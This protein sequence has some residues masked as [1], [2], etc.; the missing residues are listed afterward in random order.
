MEPSTSQPLLI[1]ADV[2]D[3]MVSHCVASPD[4]PC[5]GYLGGIPP[6]AAWV[7]PLQNIATD[8]DRYQADPSD[9]IDAVVD[10]GR[11][12]LSI[13]A[14]YHSHVGHLPIPSAADLLGHRYGDTPRVIVSVGQET[15]VRTWRIADG[16]YAELVW[17]VEK[18]PAPGDLKDRV[19]PLGVARRDGA[20]RPVSSRGRALFRLFRWLSRLFRWLGPS[21]G[22]PGDCPRDRST[23]GADPMWDPILDQPRDRAS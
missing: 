11:R 19:V 3:A 4:R 5:C 12:G 22:A 15:T 13:V 7:Y 23:P 16:S 17:H 6:R 20:P 9:Q 1:P 2:Y 21:V 18:G 14:L 10:M 8:R